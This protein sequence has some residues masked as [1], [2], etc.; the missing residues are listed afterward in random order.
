MQ[1]V[2]HRA[3][4]EAE[5][6]KWSTRADAMHRTGSG[7]SHKRSASVSDLHSNTFSFMT[8]VVRAFIRVVHAE[9]SLLLKGMSWTGD[10]AEEERTLATHLVVHVVHE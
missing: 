6:Q 10:L 9:V 2:K 7:A 5:L 8:P 3:K 4:M 1:L